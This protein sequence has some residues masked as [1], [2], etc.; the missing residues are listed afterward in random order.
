MNTLVWEVAGAII[1][2][3]GGA[4]VL[5]LALSSWLGKVWATRILDKERQRFAADLEQLRTTLE[6]ISRRLQGEIDKTVHVH[7]VHF[8]AEFRALQDVWRSLSKLRTVMASL[9]PAARIVPRGQTDDQEL[10]ELNKRFA[11]FGDALGDAVIVVDDRR[12]F[13]T[14]DI[15]TAVAQALHF[16]MAEHNSLRLQPKKTTPDWYEHGR[17]N[18]EA[19][20]DASNRVVD[21]IRARLQTLSVL[22]KDS[23]ALGRM[24]S[25][26]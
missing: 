5:M 17:K 6:Q 8:E 2:S 14:E 16:A 7:R 25:N 13:L 21:L 18:M 15:H 4:G 23:H 22:E 19:M 1:A 12:P 9:R 26:N 24:N 20:L 11:V 3:V 10:E